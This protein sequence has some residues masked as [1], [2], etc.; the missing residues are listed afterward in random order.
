MPTA[1]VVHQLAIRVSNRLRDI[2][3]PADCAGM[4]PHFGLASGAVSDPFQPRDQRTRTRERG[5]LGVLRV[6]VQV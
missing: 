5:P 2:R 3:T 1:T 6:H 4:V